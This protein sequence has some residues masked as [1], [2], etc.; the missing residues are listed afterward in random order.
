[1]LLGANA[2]VFL[3]SALLFYGTTWYVLVLGRMSIGV[4]A[5]VAQMV[6][7]AYMTEISPIGIRG[8]VGVCSQ[9]GIVIGIALANFLTAPSFH[10][11][12]SMELWRYLWLVPCGFSVFQL[13]V[14]PFCPESPAFL[15]KHQ[16]EETVFS[17]LMKLH[18]E[19]SA[20]AHLTNLRA[21]LA[22]GGGKGSSDFTVGELLAARNLRKQLIVGVL[23]KIGVQASSFDIET[24]TLYA[25]IR[26]ALM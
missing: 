6:A 2:F 21:E 15:I 7:G 3:S 20:A 11:F 24:L 17:T 5:G 19:A 10:V 12:G 13:I 26:I 22:E 23:V 14:L 18:R 9:V 1:T 25:E 8:S 16:S 4:V